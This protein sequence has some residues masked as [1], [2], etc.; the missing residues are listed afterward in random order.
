MSVRVV[1]ADCVRTWLEVRVIPRRPG[2]YVPEILH[3]DTQ[4]EPFASFYVDD[5][6]CR[7]VTG[8]QEARLHAIVFLR[9]SAVERIP[10]K[11]VLNT[12]GFTI[13]PHSASQPSL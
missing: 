10:L 9:I 6:V 11:S 3:L 8:V 2:T 1:V 13:I 4:G 5:A 7:S 12:T